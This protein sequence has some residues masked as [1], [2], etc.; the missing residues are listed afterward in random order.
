MKQLLYSK[1]NYSVI[2]VLLFIGVISTYFNQFIPLHGDEAY[3]WVWSHHLQGGYLDHPPMI[4]FL[5]SLSNFISQS[6]AGIR[7]VNVFCLFGT[8][9]YL[10]RLAVL[11]F[12]PKIGINAVL[13]FNFALATQVGYIITTP[14]SPLML[15]W[16][17]SLFYVIRGLVH[18]KTRDF[19]LSGISIGLLCLSKYTAILW[20]VSFVIFIVMKRSNL[21]L[22][23]RL[24]LA[25]LIILIIIAP[26]LYWNYQNSWISFSFQNTSL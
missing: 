1:P 19:V 15:F 21:L 20:I 26:L 3:Y 25:I 12:N 16:S 18:N 14:D 10:Y 11:I 13:I 17:I 4:A 22:D 23:K 9:L 2:V 8:S 6:E 5:I 7:L 24:Y